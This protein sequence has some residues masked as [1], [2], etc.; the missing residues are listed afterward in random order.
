LVARR[1][2]QGQLLSLLDQVYDA[3][4]TFEVQDNAELATQLSGLPAPPRR[5]LEARE[6]LRNFAVF[7]FDF[8]KASFGLASI[9]RQ[10]AWD[11]VCN[12]EVARHDYLSCEVFAQFLSGVRE[13]EEL[14][15]FVFSRRQVLDFLSHAHVVSARAGR[16]PP[17]RS[18]GG[19][20]ASP[21][22]TA[23]PLIVIPPRYVRPCAQAVF[24]VK[25]AVVV[26]EFE[27]ELTERIPTIG[28]HG[29]EL[30]VFLDTACAV[31]CEAA[32]APVPAPAAASP[33]DYPVSAYAAEAGAGAGAFAPTLAQF[34][35]GVFSGP[36]PAYT[37]YGFGDELGEYPDGPGTCQ[38][39]EQDI[40][41]RQSELEL[42]MLATITA[43][44][45][46]DEGIDISHLPLA[47]VIGAYATD[48]DR[49]AAASLARR[50]IATPPRSDLASAGRT[51]YSDEGAD[52]A[53]ADDSDDGY[54]R[55]LSRP[56]SAP[57]RALG[58]GPFPRSES[59]S[60][61]D[62]MTPLPP[63]SKQMRPADQDAD[64]E[65]A[66]AS[67]GTLGAAISASALAGLRERLHLVL[68]AL[69]AEYVGI[70]I[71]PASG[72]QLD[73][74]ANLRSGI[75]FELENGLNDLV[76]SVFAPAEPPADPVASALR[77]QLRHITRGFSTGELAD[78]VLHT[79][80]ERFCRSILGSPPLRRRIEPLAALRVTQ[81]LAE[82]AR[83]AAHSEVIEPHAL[84]SYDGGYRAL[85]PDA[86]PSDA[87]HQLQ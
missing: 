20:A 16:S 43:R 59:V 54:S 10:H 42:Q 21:S 83:V 45:M 6:A 77:D 52:G 19:S 12:L 34:R 23:S 68:E 73:I 33:G 47:E 79:A 76:A 35:G 24:G 85:G 27:T 56:S 11:L 30:S 28:K 36:L 37:P 61:V 46:L 31:Y 49:A 26:R 70:L 74:R 3:R 51:A 72:L 15:F 5:G 80:L 58:A 53:P 22:G 40:L 50:S 57:R 63:T 48:D 66:D 84:R 25:N 7:V 82:H 81:A 14:S 78:D 62:V 29:V 87:M 71:A 2:Q 8:L 65:A 9:T 75:L 32:A 39:E 1:K 86:G 64:P 44:R 13:L 60:E 17:R 69:T 55:G 38:G 4:Y 41:A 18:P 67:G